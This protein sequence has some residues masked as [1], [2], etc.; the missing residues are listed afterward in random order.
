MR[1]FVASLA[2]LALTSLAAAYE[3]GDQLVIARPAEMQTILGSTHQLTPGSSITV[4]AVE[5]Q[6][7]KVAAPRVGWIDSSAVIPAKQA[8]EY[9]SDQIVKASDKAAALLARGKL[10]M[11][12]GGLDS[13]KLEQAVAD[14]DESIRLAPS[15]EAHTARGF[16]WKRMGDKDKAIANFDE[17]IRLN[18]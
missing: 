5:G 2:V 12:R 1:R 10:R 18:P 17:A 15:S 3:P 14:L 9:F 7:L 8:D 16:A 13:A 6:K 4:R 11:E